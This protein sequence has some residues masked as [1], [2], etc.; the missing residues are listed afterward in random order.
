MQLL[1]DSPAGDFYDIA[2]LFFIL[3]FSRLYPLSFPFTPFKP[4]HTLPVLLFY[5]LEASNRPAVQP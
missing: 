3:R 1:G 5:L 4:S 2:S